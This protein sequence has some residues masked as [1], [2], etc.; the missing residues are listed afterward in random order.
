VPR[1]E[2]MRDR[3]PSLYRP[4]DL[5]DSLLTRFLQAVGYA[6]D[7]VD[8]ESTD[9]M[10]SHWFDYSDNA[11]YSPY[12]LSA[13]QQQHKTL[14]KPHDPELLSFPYVQDLARLAS[15]L[16]LQPWTDPLEQRE[17]VEAFRKRIEDVIA[18]YEQ[19]LGTLPAIRRIVEA[20]LPRNLNVLDT[21]KD[22]PFEVEEF[23]PLAVK[24]QAVPARGN[25]LEMVGPLMRW[26]LTN[27][28]MQAAPSTLYIQGVQ[29][30]DSAIDATTNPVIELYRFRHT[31]PRLGIAYKGTLLPDQTLRLRPAFSSWL[32]QKSAVLRAISNPD[33]KQPADPTAQGPWQPI[34][35]SPTGNIAAIYQTSNRMLWVAVNDGQ[36]GRLFRFDGKE[37]KLFITGAPTITC[38]AQ[39]RESLFIG[40]A[41]GLWRIRLDVEPPDPMPQIPVVG[42]RLITEIAD[43]SGKQVNAIHLDKHGRW[44]IGLNDGAVILTITDKDTIAPSGLSGVAINAIS[45]DKS[46]RVY[47]GSPM[48]AYQ[49]QPGSDRFYWYH[50]KELSE[51]VPDWQYFTLSAGDHQN[52]LPKNDTVFLP[53][54]KC[55]H[56]GP[57]GSLWFGTERGIARYLARSVR[58]L[59]Y[60]TLLQ[61]FP[62]FTS[63][64]VFAI[65]EDERGGIWF[66]TDTGLFRY[67][68]RDFW[69]LQSNK[70]VQ[71]GRADLLYN[72]KAD[73][74]PRGAY[75]FLRSANKWQ[76]FDT[77]S[78][79]WAAAP[80]T[81]V[82][83]KES[84]VTCVTWTDECKG[85][86]GK[87]DGQNF[88]DPKPITEGSLLMR[89]KPSETKIVNGGIPAVP[90]MPVGTSLWRYLSLEPDGM[91]DPNP[92]AW[93][94]EGRQVQP[95]PDVPA[96]GEGRYDVVAPQP[97]SDFDEAVFAFNPS[98]KVWFSWEPKQPLSVLV[99]LKKSAEQ[100]IDPAVVD[101]VWQGM[102]QV[103]PAGSRAILAV[104]NVV[105]KI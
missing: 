31:A 39:E 2:Q 63:G 9:V 36:S 29:P 90:R 21:E 103:R 54:V 6:L 98:A 105:V 44:W 8:R 70:W 76:V 104:D 62:D 32:G 75:R 37:W 57:D 41:K 92:P 51:L 23:A 64:P 93:T 73:P 79:T 49:L 45:E 38:L 28:G 74:T 99:R 89:H 67:D 58:G 1:L 94:I 30:Q 80:D 7:K 35:K 84:P 16:P 96:P 43:L 81:P 61:A 17:L 48:G 66:C 42:A 22:L 20:Q 59:S 56:R 34:D 71:L 97:P 101:R 91:K 25:P 10:Q 5:D 55:V 14:P 47:F 12:F 82:T 4:D 19:G 85:E 50:G 72:A 15:I 77:R 40:N 33:D 65:Q 27:T 102:Q 60:E 69:Q 88:T 100:E 46:G 52:N 78:S 86:I 95:P 68:G 87:W 11:L 18:L 13:Y 3:L 83:T 24:Q 53:A 26:S